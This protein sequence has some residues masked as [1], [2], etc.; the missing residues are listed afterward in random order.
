MLKPAREVNEMTGEGI[1]WLGGE[2]R[3][4]SMLIRARSTAPSPNSLSF[5]A[6]DFSLH[7]PEPW[8]VGHEIPY[9]EPARLPLPHLLSK[10]EPSSAEFARIF[11]DINARIRGGEFEK[12]VPMVSEDFEFAAPL[13]HAMFSQKVLPG[14]FAYGFQFEDEGMVGQTPEVLFAVDGAILRTMALAGTGAAD[15][16]DLTAD[17]KEM[18]E[19]QLVIRHITTEL[20]KFGDLTIGTTTERVYGK[21]KHLHTPIEVKLIE[22]PRFEELV[23]RLHPTAALGGWPRK[24]AVAWLE[25]QNFHETRRRFGAPFGFVDGS[26]MLCVVAIRNVQWKGHRL[27]VSSGCGVVLESEVLRE[28]KELELKRQSVFR[29]LEV[30]I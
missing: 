16:P 17:P 14:R 11:E 30:E 19:H 5:F 6:P 8:L 29:A 13:E 15:G 26:K 2:A 12:V 28:W 9:R 20:K 10:V 21:L 18:H 23:A 24:P 7:A 1:A 22:A 27:Q 25:K 4:K 3:R